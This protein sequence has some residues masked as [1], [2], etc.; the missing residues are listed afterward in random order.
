MGSVIAK[1]V[2]T[3]YFPADEYAKVIEATYRLAEYAERSWAPEKRGAR[4]GA[5]TELLR[6]SGLRI[7]DAVTLERSRLVGNKLLL[8]QAK[9]GTPAHVPQALSEPQLL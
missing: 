6:W 5:L 9:T 4:I 1:H 8:Y 2:S 7:R 3:D